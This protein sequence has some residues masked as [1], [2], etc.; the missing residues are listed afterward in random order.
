MLSTY[1]PISPVKNNCIPPNINE[2]TTTA[3]KFVR[4]ELL[5]IKN[6]MAIK[7]PNRTPIKDIIKPLNN[8]IRAGILLVET[9]PLI[10]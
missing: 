10:A 6:E 7:I 3:G 5:S 8:A 2:I 9:K 1:S 4:V